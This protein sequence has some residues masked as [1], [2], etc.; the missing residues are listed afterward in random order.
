VAR[1]Y[2]ARFDEHCAVVRERIEKKETRD[3]ATA[4]ED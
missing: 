3:L 2:L 1:R 4:T